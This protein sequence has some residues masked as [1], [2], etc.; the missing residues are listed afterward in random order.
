MVNDV[1]NWQSNRFNTCAQLKINRR[2]SAYIIITGLYD[3]WHV[4][5][6]SIGCRL[7]RAVFAAAEC[8]ARDDIC[9]DLKVVTMLK[10]CPTEKSTDPPSTSLTNR[11]N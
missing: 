11:A 5:F 7:P 4:S 2:L 3:G 1:V 6:A 8:S 9:K 10:Y